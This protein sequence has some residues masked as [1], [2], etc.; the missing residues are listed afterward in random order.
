MY[1]VDIVSTIKQLKTWWTQR[2]NKRIYLTYYRMLFIKV[3]MS[4]G[5]VNQMS[6]LQLLKSTSKCDQPLCVRAS[7]IQLKSIALSNIHFRM[8]CVTTEI[9]DTSLPQ[10][11]Q[12]LQ[13]CQQNDN[14]KTLSECQGV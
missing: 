2:E 12:K 7:F 8:N 10:F 13:H 9:V 4:H 6:T 14:I 1:T 11:T 3:T 5:H